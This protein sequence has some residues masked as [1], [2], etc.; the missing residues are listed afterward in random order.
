VVQHGPDGEQGLIGLELDRVEKVVTVGDQE[1]DREEGRARQADQRREDDHAHADAP[2][3]LK[4]EGRTGH[5]PVQFG[6]VE[7]FQ[8]HQHE[9]ALHQIGA[10]RRPRVPGAEEECGH[11]RQRD[12]DGRAQADREAGQIQGWQGSPGVN[13]IS[14]GH[15]QEPRLA[16]VIE[17]HQH[18]HQPA[19]RIDGAD[20]FRRERCTC[21]RWKRH[22]MHAHQKRA[23]M[24]TV[25]RRG[26]P[27][28]TQNEL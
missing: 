4:P 17:E 27:T 16:Q 10:C 24:L 5:A 25:T 6:E 21:R 9:T 20:A 13:R 15:V 3:H 28:P 1:P 11:A 2:D 23:V 14:D 8:G 7:D 22:S 26:S 12:E 19:E 18:H